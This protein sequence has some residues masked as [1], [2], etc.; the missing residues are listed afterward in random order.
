MNQRRTEM[1]MH[2]GAWDASNL[3]VAS[4]EIVPLTLF[5]VVSN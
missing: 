3:T 1:D 2:T 5:N 4:V